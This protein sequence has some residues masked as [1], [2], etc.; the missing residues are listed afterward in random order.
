MSCNDPTCPLD[1]GEYIRTT[2]DPTVPRGMAYLS[3]IFKTDPYLGEGDTVTVQI[4]ARTRTGTVELRG[5]AL[6]V[7]MPGD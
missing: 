6:V 1:H 7:V 3:P 4:G 2:V 5:E